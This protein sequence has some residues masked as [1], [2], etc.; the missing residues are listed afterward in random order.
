MATDFYAHPLNAIL[1][2]TMVGVQLNGMWERLEAAPT[3]L[4]MAY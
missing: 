3:Y 1:L 4:F 2:T